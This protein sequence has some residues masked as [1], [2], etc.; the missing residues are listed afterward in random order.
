MTMKIVLSEQAHWQDVIK[1]VASGEDVVIERDGDQ[2]AAVIPYTDYLE[3]LDALDD[4]RA[5]RQ[6]RAALGEW[7]RDPALAR[8]W[9]EVEAELRSEGRP[10][11]EP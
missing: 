1:T 10:G 5:A 3:L 9:L 8:P 11:D 2:V 4:L 6:A 7:R